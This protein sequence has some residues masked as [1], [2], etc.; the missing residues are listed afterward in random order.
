MFE[1]IM[2]VWKVKVDIPRKNFL[3]RF[4]L[5]FLYL[6]C[7]GLQK[8]V[9]GERKICVSVCQSSVD[10]TNGGPGLVVRLIHVTASGHFN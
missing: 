7:V 4:I 9:H 1:Y 5:I 6:F 3:F 2:D 8:S 10:I